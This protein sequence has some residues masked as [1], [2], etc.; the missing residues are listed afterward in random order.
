MGYMEYLGLYSG[1]IKRRIGWATMKVWHKISHKKCNKYQS[2]AMYD[3][4][5]VHDKD[6]DFKQNFIH[7][8]HV[9]LWSLER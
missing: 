3:K 7:E 6:N 5:H 9:I 1:E 4:F 8:F 2:L